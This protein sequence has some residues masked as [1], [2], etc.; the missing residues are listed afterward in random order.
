MRPEQTEDYIKAYC[1]GLARALRYIKKHDGEATK[2]ISLELRLL[3][4]KIEPNDPPEL[5]DLEDS[6]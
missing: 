6:Q 3:Q 4:M 5:V 1:A 2:Y